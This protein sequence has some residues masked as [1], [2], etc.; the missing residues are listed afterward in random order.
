MIHRLVIPLLMIAAISGQAPTVP[1]IRIVFPDGHSEKAAMTYAL[2]DPAKDSWDL[3]HNV[4]MQSGSAHLELPAETDRFKALVWAPGCQMKH[5]DVPVEKSDIELHFACEPL[6]TVLFRG[7]VP[8][9]GVGA[10]PR[11][12][13]AYVSLE[14]LFW[15]YDLKPMGGSS[16]APAIYE[17][18]TAPVSPDGSFK[19]TL[20]DLSADPIASRESWATLEFRIIGAKGQHLLQPQAGEGIGLRGGQ[21]KVEPSYPVAVTFK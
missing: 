13:V 9:I 6:K 1:K 20:P 17:I 18:A 8:G 2:H 15:F 21:I 14:T 12:S 7:R 4:S 19:I 11:I 3:F 10:S 5:L 16:P